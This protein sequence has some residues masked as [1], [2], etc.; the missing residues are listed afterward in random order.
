MSLLSR[1]IGGRIISGTLWVL[2]VLVTLLGFFFLIEELDHVGE[3]RYATPDALGYVLLTL[4]RYAYEIFPIAALIGSLVGLGSLASHSELTAMR[5]AG[6]SLAR[7]VSAVLL[8]GGLMILGITLVGEGIAPAA[9]QY[10]QK[11]RAEKR[12]QQITLK[13]EYGFWARDGS[14]FINIRKILPGSRLQDIY[15]FEFDRSTQALKAATHAAYSEYR[16]GHWLLR[17]IAQTLFSEDRL[18]TRS[19][20]HATWASMVDPAL[21]SFIALDPNLLPSWGLYRY[22]KFMRENGQSATR[23][24][25]VFWGKVLTPF[26]TLVMLFLSVPFVFGSLRSVGIGQRVFVGVMVGMGFFLL[27]RIS[28]YMSLVYGLEPLLA[29][30]LPGLAMLALAFWLARRVH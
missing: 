16:E 19:M 24:E 8:T 10:A 22:V 30:A 5:T 1:Y 7:I 23:F 14:A 28:S 15:I 29:S 9:E 20:D 21:L 26:V 6:F 11:M 25:V 17:D 3:G 4:P 13:T 12:S 18:E 27:T 2:L